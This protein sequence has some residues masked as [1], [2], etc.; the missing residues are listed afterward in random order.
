[1]TASRDK[2]LGK[3]RAARPPFPHAQPRPAK[4]LPVTTVAE[5]A[6]DALLDRFR[7]EFEALNGEL[8]VVEGDAAARQ[9][10]LDL[11]ASHETKRI[12]SWHFKHIP[13]PKLYTAIQEAGYIIDYPNIILD[14]PE[15]REQELT[16]LES[17]TVG[18]TG[19]DAVAA[20]TGSLIVSTG[21]GKP[22][23]PT[24]LPFVHIAVVTLAQFIPNIET[25][26][27]NQRATGMETIQQSTN[28]CFISGPSRTADIEK[29]LV[30]G[31]H[32]PKRV[33]V[34]VKR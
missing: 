9:Q 27:E 15:A 18:L 2:I 20:T 29:Q 10:V 17:A 13:V 32:G 11:L 3:L 21:A 1:M 19:A 31:V 34:V 12:A 28:I 24:V 16:R 7:Q 33:Q 22:R 6:P 14:D 8:F 5:S 4:H 30:L 23:I 25:W 26:L